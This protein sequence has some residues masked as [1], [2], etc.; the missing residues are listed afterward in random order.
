[1]SNE[2]QQQANSQPTEVSTGLQPDIPYLVH[3][4]TGESIRFPENQNTI[5]LGK[6]NENN[7]PDVDLLELPNSEIISRQHAKIHLESDNYYIEDIGSSNGTYV[8]NTPV[9]EGQSHQLAAGD[10][11]ALGKEDKATFVFKV[12]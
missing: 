4:Q 3:I 7:P 5:L 11:I 6:S 9:P 12:P 2:N 8:N 1:M 10:V